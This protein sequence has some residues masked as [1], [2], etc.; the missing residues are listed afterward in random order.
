MCGQVLRWCALK[1]PMERRHR[2]LQR[3]VTS[4]LWTRRTVDLED[5][6]SVQPVVFS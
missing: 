3:Q 6:V 1:I 4:V 5:R 2:G